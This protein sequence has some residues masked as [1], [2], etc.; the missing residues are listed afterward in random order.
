M[1]AGLASS[2]RG[3]RGFVRSSE[4]LLRNQGI[5]FAERTTDSAVVV[6]S[7]RHGTCGNHVAARSP[8][9]DSFTASEHATT[10][11]PHLHC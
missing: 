1:R 3:R 11:N 7:S 6:A 8:H 4:P 9:Y 2:G 10:I 5:W